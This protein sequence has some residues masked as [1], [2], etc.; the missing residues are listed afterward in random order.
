MSNERKKTPIN[1]KETDWEAID[2]LIKS[3]D[4]YGL[5]RQEIQKFVDQYKN[6]DNIELAKSY[7]TIRALLNDWFG[8][9][10]VT[11]VF[12]KTKEEFL[13]EASVLRLKLILHNLQLVVYFASKKFHGFGNQDNITFMDV[14]QAGNIGLIA[15]V[16]K[17]DPDMGHQFSTYAEHWI[18]ESIRKYG[19]YP[20]ENSLDIKQSGRPIIRRIHKYHETYV[21]EKKQWIDISNP[22]FLTAA[23]QYLQELEQFSNLSYELM[24][25]IMVSSQKVLSI[26]NLAYEDDD[27]GNNGDWEKMLYQIGTGYRT[28]PD[29]YLETALTDKLSPEQVDKLYTIL[30]TV[31]SLKE[32]EAIQIWHMFGTAF[33]NLSPELQI[34]DS[35]I[36]KRQRKLRS[37]YER[38]I[39]K[40]KKSKAITT[41]YREIE[42]S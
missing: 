22:I 19:V 36:S 27:G 1:K 7:K 35:Y 11:T 38:A 26:E 33:Q 15:A 32:L 24:T 21:Q 12:G 42:Q 16:D 4:I 37:S 23:Y 30:G 31:L 40:L 25:Q 18:N 3:D 6:V 8:Q 5:Y 2:S 13:S 41:F 10:S 9:E 29:P 28:Q 20:M 14:I 34:D 17:F 39:S